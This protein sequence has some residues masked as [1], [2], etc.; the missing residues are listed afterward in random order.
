MSLK[1]S[2]GSS[3]F[4][5]K[6]S[7]VN[8]LDALQKKAWLQK[9]MAQ[10]G[11]FMVSS[12]KTGYDKQKGPKGERWPALG[13]PPAYPYKPDTD[14]VAKWWKKEY[15]VRK[16]DKALLNHDGS[17]MRGSL[18]FTLINGGDAVIIGYGVR[19]EAEKAKKHQFGEA[20]EY[21]YQ[22]KPN[23]PIKKRRMKPRIRPTL[24][25][26][27]WHRLGTQHD[28]YVVRKIFKDN[29][30]KILEGRL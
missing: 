23:K 19:Q 30:V 9:S 28:V 7:I 20:G 12:T 13:G 6:D 1:I 27:N 5:K 17:G 2:V 15:R 14:G 26:S 16:G 10:A 18:T 22:T 29:V 4:S 8:R 25:F 11:N 24:G 3:L 21:R